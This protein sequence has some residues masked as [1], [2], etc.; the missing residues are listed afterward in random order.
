MFYDKTTVF[1]L[2]PSVLKNCSRAPDFDF[3][4][5]ETD[6]DEAIEFPNFSSEQCI[7][8]DIHL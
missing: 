7:L 4:S 5:G 6:S 8:Y 1:T 3:Y 2:T